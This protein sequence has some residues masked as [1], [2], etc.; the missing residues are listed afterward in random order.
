M[1]LEEL[2]ALYTGYIE[3]VSRL[4][5]AKKP[6]DGLLGFGKKISDDPCHE[7]F[8]EELEALLERFAQAGPSSEEVRRVLSFVYHAPAAYSEPASAYWMLNAVQ[9]LTQELVK[10]LSRED[11]S[12][13]LRQY[14]EDIPRSQRLPVQKKVGKALKAA[15]KK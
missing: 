2:K 14:E 3:K 8:A 15:A 11:A 4:E 12:E 13:L 1:W 6:A 7:A 5:M 10:V 9:G